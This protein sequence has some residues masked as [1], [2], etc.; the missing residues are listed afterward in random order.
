MRQRMEFYKVISLKKWGATKPGCT[1][2]NWNWLFIQLK[3]QE[4][5][6]RNPRTGEVNVSLRWTFTY[7]RMRTILGFIGLINT[8]AKGRM[9]VFC[10][11]SMVEEANHGGSDLDKGWLQNKLCA[12]NNTLYICINNLPKSSDSCSFQ[13]KLASLHG[14]C[15][16]G[17][18]QSLFRKWCL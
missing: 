7:S 2:C 4:R 13:C 18:T 17:R 5:N 3:C 16:F 11:D 14:T 12:K 6:V 8:G 15:H 9:N 10:H 1:W